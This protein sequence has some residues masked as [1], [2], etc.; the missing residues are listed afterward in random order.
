VPLEEDLTGVLYVIVNHHLHKK[1]QLQIVWEYKAIQN[2]IALV[3]NLVTKL[4]ETAQP[5]INNGLWI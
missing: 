3:R 2:R 5:Y 1:K 4:E